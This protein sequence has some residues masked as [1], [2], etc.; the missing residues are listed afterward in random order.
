M[1]RIIK[2]LTCFV[3]G[4]LFAQQPETQV[5]L[6]EETRMKIPFAGLIT[7]STEIHCAEGM[8]HTISH[9]E[10]DRFTTRIMAGGE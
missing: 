3:F 10:F 6:L 8:I 9:I 4:L 5:F 1:V 2:V 7:T